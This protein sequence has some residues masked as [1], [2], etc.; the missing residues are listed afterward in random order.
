VKQKWYCI[1][2]QRWS[3]T[4][5]NSKRVTN[6]NFRIVVTSEWAWDNRI[7]KG[8]MEKFKMKPF[9]WM[10][11]WM[12]DCMV[13]HCVEPLMLPTECVLFSIYSLFNKN[14]FNLYSCL[15]LVFCVVWNRVPVLS[16][17][18]QMTSYPIIICQVEILFP[19]RMVTLV[20]QRIF[21][22]I[23]IYFWALPPVLSPYL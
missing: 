14:H 20:I 13:V 1:E 22:H 7:R 4:T 10:N 12:N 23:G 5:K 17:C 18:R 21:I 6:T 19:F 16:Y 2:I 11:K 3:K 8:E 9:S 15:N